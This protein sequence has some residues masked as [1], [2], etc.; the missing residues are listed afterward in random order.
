MV[1]NHASA[2]EMFEERARTASDPELREWARRMVPVLEHHLEEAG[3]LQRELET[4][5]PAGAPLRIVPP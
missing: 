1:A 4:V 2:L 5:T 3:S